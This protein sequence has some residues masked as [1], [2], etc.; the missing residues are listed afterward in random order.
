[1]FLERFLARGSLFWASTWLFEAGLCEPYVGDYGRQAQAQAE[2]ARDTA[3]NFPSYHFGTG[4]SVVDEEGGGFR[5]LSPRESADKARALAALQPLSKR[6]SYLDEPSPAVV[7]KDFDQADDYEVGGGGVGTGRS[8]RPTAMGDASKE[9]VEN[10]YYVLLQ[11]AID[12][13]VKEEFDT[14]FPPPL[15]QQIFSAAEER[16]FLQFLHDGSQNHPG[17]A[18]FDL[19]RASNDGFELTGGSGSSKVSGGGSERRSGHVGAYVFL[20]EYR[21]SF[22]FH[23]GPI[24]QASS[25]AFTKLNSVFKDSEA[26]LTDNMKRVAAKDV[27]LLQHRFQIPRNFMQVYGVQYDVRIRVDLSC[28]TVE[29]VGTHYQEIFN[30]VSLFAQAQSKVPSPARIKEASESLA[31]NPLVSLGFSQ[32]FIFPHATVDELIDLHLIDWFHLGFLGG[33]QASGNSVSGFGSGSISGGRLP[34]SSDTDL[35]AF[36]MVQKLRQE[37]LKTAQTLERL[38]I[39]RWRPARNQLR[40]M[41][42]LQPRPEARALLESHIN[43]GPKL[44]ILAGCSHANLYRIIFGP[45]DRLLEG[46]AVDASVPNAAVRV[47]RTAPKICIQSPQPASVFYP[48]ER[49]HA[50]CMGFYPSTTLA[51]AV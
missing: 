22:R 20:K 28:P 26:V 6:D 43:P 48:D 19:A 33:N 23:P 17:F 34:Q 42:L 27:E 37:M 35:S 1:M 11:Q 46:S 9:I 29:Q 38:G 31:K 2:Q 7:V 36:M 50:Q 16:P 39:E 5:A 3:R 51:Y 8:D 25:G 24:G 40:L 14:A 47:G 32:D 18:T 12:D 21:A 44:D 49:F 30:V 41:S 13:S 4:G 45:A 15:R 10:N